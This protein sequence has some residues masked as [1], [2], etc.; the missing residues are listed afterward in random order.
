[1]MWWLWAW[2]ALWAQSP[3]KGTTG[4]GMDAWVGVGHSSAVYFA[5]P[6]LG[7]YPLHRWF[8]GG[9]V[10]VGQAA[11]RAGNDSYLTAGPMTRYY[12][13]SSKITP[14]V[15][16]GVEYGVSTRGAT[17]FAALH[18]GGGASFAVKHNFSVEALAQY[19]YFGAKIGPDKRGFDAFM[20][21]VGF[22][23]WLKKNKTKK[24]K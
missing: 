3:Q 8:V 11:F 13:F 6:Y 15:Q 18:L 2:A 24:T 21:G 5:T 1:M 23:G 10:S 22:Q 20:V 4:A 9:K 17:G 12:L 14:L 16:A 19:M 7:A